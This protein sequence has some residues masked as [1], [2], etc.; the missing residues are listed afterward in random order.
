MIPDSDQS[1][2]GR[3]DDSRISASDSHFSLA[4][5]I[6]MDIRRELMS[7]DAWNF[8]SL[9]V[10]RVKDGSGI[11]LQGVLE[12]DDDDDVQILYDLVREI[13]GAADVRDQLIIQ[14]RA[15]PLAEE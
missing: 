11:C 1:I 5:A 7:R 14:R 2:H 6:E 9:V 3:C 13:S 10:H 12:C 15:K 4:H 8:Q